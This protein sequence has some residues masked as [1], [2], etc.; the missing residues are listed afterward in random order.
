MPGCDAVG[1]GLPQWAPGGGEN[2]PDCVMTR[3][4]LWIGDEQIVARG[5]FVAPAPLVEAAQALAPLYG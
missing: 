3:Q 5:A 4:S 1:L 2:H